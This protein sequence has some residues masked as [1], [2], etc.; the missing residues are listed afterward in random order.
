MVINMNKKDPMEIV[1]EIMERDKTILNVL[2]D[3]D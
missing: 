3:V 1:M 2:K